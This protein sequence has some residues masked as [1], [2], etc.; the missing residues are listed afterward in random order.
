MIKGS[1]EK[2]AYE[3]F[4]KYISS[5]IVMQS[6]VQGIDFQEKINTWKF[7]VCQRLIEQGYITAREVI[8]ICGLEGPHFQSQSL[9]GWAHPQ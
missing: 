7:D 6:L 3:P 8:D 5:F 9:Q 1:T 4:D 2:E